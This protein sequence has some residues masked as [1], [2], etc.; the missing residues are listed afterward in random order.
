MKTFQTILAI[1]SLAFAATPASLSARSV[2]VTSPDGQIVVDITDNNGVSFSL[3]RAGKELLHPS[4]IALDVQGI[5]TQAK[6]K[7]SSLKRN[8]KETI[9]A[10]FHHTPVIN[11]EWNDL[12]VRLSNGENLTFRIFN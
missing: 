6:I 11:A 5:P 10:P 3:S 2:S 1:A 9:N 4:S 12:T 7:N 8:V